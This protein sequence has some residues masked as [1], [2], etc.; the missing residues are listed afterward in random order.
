MEYLVGE[1]MAVAEKVE[2]KE[3]VIMEANKVAITA[4]EMMVVVVDKV[5]TKVAEDLMAGDLMVENSVEEVVE[6]MMVVEKKVEV[7]MGVIMEA[8]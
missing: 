8:T 6:A 7:N 4:E 5:V 2:V 1:T 3:Q